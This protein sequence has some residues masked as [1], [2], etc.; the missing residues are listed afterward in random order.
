MRTEIGA[1]DVEGAFPLAR[2][3]ALGLSPDGKH[4]CTREVAGGS[5]CA[6]YIDWDKE[7]SASTT[8]AKISRSRR[9][10]SSE[11]SALPAPRRT[12]S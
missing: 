10:C 6:R 8:P 3:H 5:P 12:T 9:S 1:G 4:F 2:T 7:V 11:T